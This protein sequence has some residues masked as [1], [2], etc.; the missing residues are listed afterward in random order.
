MKHRRPLA[1]CTCGDPLGMADRDLQG[2]VICTWALYIARDWALQVDLEL[3]ESKGTEIKTDYR[4]ISNV[5]KLHRK[6][7]RKSC[8]PHGC[9]PI[10]RR[11]QLR[12][13]SSSSTCSWYVPPRCLIGMTVPWENILK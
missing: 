11:A 4:E 7:M 8:N 9:L 1:A 3:W 5:S 6:A 12:A 10:S 13:G 2:L